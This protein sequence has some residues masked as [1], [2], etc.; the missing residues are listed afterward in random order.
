M[1]TRW[2]LAHESVSLRYFEEIASGS[3]YEGRRDLGNIHPG[4]G[5]RYKGRGPIQLTGRSNY[6]VA[7]EI[8]CV[9]I[10]NLNDTGSGSLR[11]GITTGTGARTILF[12]VSGIIPLNSSLSI[13]NPRIYIAGQSAPG[14]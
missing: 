14:W 10:T 2:Q 12:K 8:H 9:S 1:R 5:V 11:S 4:D 6:R 7:G 13:S 3:A